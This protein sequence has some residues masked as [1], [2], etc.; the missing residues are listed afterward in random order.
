MVA[1]WL[2]VARSQLVLLVVSLRSGPNNYRERESP[3]YCFWQ[4]LIWIVTIWPV[5]RSAHFTFND[6]SCQPSVKLPSYS[7]LT[8]RSKCFLLSLLTQ[9]PRI[10]IFHE[11]HHQ[12]MERSGLNN[13]CWFLARPSS[14][15]AIECRGRG[16]SGPG[17]VIFYWWLI[18]RYPAALLGNG[19][20]KTWFPT[21]SG[22]QQP[23]NHIASINFLQSSAGPSSLI[24]RGGQQAKVETTVSVGTL[25][26]LLPQ[27]KITM[28]FSL[29]CQNHNLLSIKLSQC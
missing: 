22:S 16:C 5:S 23:G 3:V 13:Q 2:P 28:G 25:L 27:H 18:A 15:P 24:R 6:S 9:L 12:R 1:R 10:P 8:T 21:S 26:Y 14:G 4:P 7:P 17:L 20:V 29:L 11:L 19:F